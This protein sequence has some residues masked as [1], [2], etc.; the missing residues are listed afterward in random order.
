MGK[1]KSLPSLEKITID[2]IRTAIT[3]S[4]PCNLRNDNYYFEY[5]GEY[6]KSILVVNRAVNNNNFRSVRGWDAND[7]LRRLKFTVFDKEEKTPKLCDLTED[8]NCI[9]LNKMFTGGYLQENENI[10]HEAINLFEADDSNVYLYLNSMGTVDFKRLKKNTSM[11]MVKK[12]TREKKL[13]VIALVKNLEV[14]EGATYKNIRKATEKQSFIK[15]GGV[16]A[17]KIMENNRLPG[18][19]GANIIAT[20]VTKKENIQLPL[21]PI[22]LNWGAYQ[23]GVITVGNSERFPSTSMRVYYYQKDQ[24]KKDQDKEDKDGYSVLERLI[25]D[26]TIWEKPTDSRLPNF[27]KVENVKSFTSDNSFNIFRISGNEDDELSFSNM[28]AYFLKDVE[29]CDYFFKKLDI[30]LEIDSENISNYVQREE[31]DIDILIRGKNSIIAIEN[32]IHSSINGEV[33]RGEPEDKISSWEEKAWKDENGDKIE[34]KFSL[35]VTEGKTVSQLAKYYIYAKSRMMIEYKSKEDPTML[36]FCP[37][38]VAG[39]INKNKLKKYL[40]GKEYRVI[41]YS[42]ICDIFENYYNERKNLHSES[43]FVY[44]NEFIKAIKKHTKK[45]DNNYE[46]EMIRR[47]KNAIFQ[48]QN[49]NNN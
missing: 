1:K 21:K 26:T 46:E 39:T 15:Y 41:F 17:A 16:S 45:E 22:I 23:E 19:D 14:V 42:E 34:K 47:F 36:L 9:L 31:F 12:V 10:G 3:K 20:F 48:Y 44:L 43:K 29:I 32:K 27:S 11:L 38:Y 33:L 35:E 37:N 6:Y 13:E 5:N 4:R 49:F 8:C 7:L 18:R 28:I 25:D 30:Q 24:G 40:C 2:D